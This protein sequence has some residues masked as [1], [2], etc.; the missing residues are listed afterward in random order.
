[1][2]FE[3]LQDFGTTLTDAKDC[4]LLPQEVLW[5]SPLTIPFLFLPAVLVGVPSFSSSA[6]VLPSSFLLVELQQKETEKSGKQNT[7]TEE[8]SRTELLLEFYGYLCKATMDESRL[9]VGF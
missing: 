5:V 4:K 2:E 3:A 7:K 1:M 8:F 6:E 9:L